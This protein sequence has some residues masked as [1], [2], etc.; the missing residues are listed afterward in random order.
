MLKSIEEKKNS[1]TSPKSLAT[2][3]T[4]DTALSGYQLSQ[5]RKK[6]VFE[7]I[8]DLSKNELK[9]SRKILID[10]FCLGLKP[11][12]SQKTLNEVIAFLKKE[13]YIRLALNRRFYILLRSKYSG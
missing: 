2:Q 13:G 11:R 9:C 6:A 10:Y 3:L 12:L 1:L 8:Q 4:K 7:Y 5:N